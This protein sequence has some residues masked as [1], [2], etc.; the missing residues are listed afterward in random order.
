MAYIGQ[1]FSKLSVI[2]ERVVAHQQTYRH[3]TEDELVAK[4][5]EEKA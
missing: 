2:Q 1:E 3:M 4:S 5:L